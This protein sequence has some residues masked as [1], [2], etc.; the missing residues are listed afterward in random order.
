[1]DELL[2][3]AEMH[4]ADTMSIAA[5]VPGE[6]LM[7]AAGA[8]VVR[9]VC[10]RWAPHP[11][12][13]LCGPGNNGGD[14][15]VIARLLLEAGWPVRLALLG[16]RSAL[17]GDAAL[18]AERWP[19]P[20]EAADPYI[21]KGN[22]LVIDALFG[23]GLSR[24]LEGVAKAIVEAMEGRT[25]VAVDVPSGLHGDS[26]RVLGVAPHAALTVTFFRRKPGHVLL[27]GRTLCGEVLVAD[28]GISDRVLD[29]IV[30][31]TAV[32]GPDLWRHLFPWPMLDGHKYA[33]GHA[34]VL[35][36]ARM[37]GAARLASVAALRAGAGLV[38]VACPQEA[39]TV[40]AS[41]SPSVIVEPMA[42]DSEFA[43]ILGDDRKNAVLLGPGAGVGAR[44]RAHV[45]AALAADKACVLD[46]DALTSFAETSDDL[47]DHLNA[48]CV[49]TPHEGEFARLFG[50]S[51]GMDSDKLSR[52]RAAASRSGAVV[53]LKGADT[54]IAA[55]DGRA[56]ININAPAE[57]A[58]AGS[59]DV[60]A[61]IVLGLIAQGME[62]FE[63]ACAAVWLH[64]EAAYT[65]G[66]GLISEDLP[67][68]LPGVLRAL[69]G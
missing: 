15:F 7:E 14:G 20:I 8:A 54:V 59:G 19:G 63:A 50:S 58:T 61:G 43:Q 13:V 11:T 6:L 40:Y 33:R 17:V 21:L 34:V 51:V 66:P 64:G 24:P 65:I 26:G 28:I 62:A 47:L 45:A 56:V 12:A 3:V 48:R 16:T 67:N 46:A 31:Q 29:G 22:P 37:T 52:T 53:L 30:P 10:A 39:F 5:G 35:G 9:A 44:T 69:K 32:N 42:G 4:R 49:L 41:G 2:S 1:M 55:P 57:L 60:L 27:P 38:T 23:A 68:A 25:V 18:A 36:G